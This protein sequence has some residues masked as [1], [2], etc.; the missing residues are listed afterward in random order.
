MFLDLFTF[1]PTTLAYIG[2]SVGLGAMAIAIA[3]ML[4]GLFVLI[5]VLW[6]PLKRLFKSKSKKPRNK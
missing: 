6:Y 5:G 3:F 4:G 2:P 1:T